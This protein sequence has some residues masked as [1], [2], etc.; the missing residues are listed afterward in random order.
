MDV[1]EVKYC[2]NR[3]KD[4]DKDAFGAL[5][6]AYKDMVFTVCLRMLTSEADAEEAAQDVFVKAFR[7]IG[8]FQAKAKFSTWLYRIAYNHCISVIRKKVKMIDLVDDIPEGEVDEGEMNGLESISAEE[9]SR[10][11]KLAIESLAETDAVV[12]TLF[13]YDELSLEEIAGVTGL[14]SSN[15]RIKL[16]RSRKKMY[17]VICENLKSEVSSI[18]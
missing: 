10:Y 3:V 15:I 4:G 9:R 12:V 14:S 7:S 2:I 13:Y 18:L 8:S 11:L 16:H 17:Q 6:D 5:V 1:Q